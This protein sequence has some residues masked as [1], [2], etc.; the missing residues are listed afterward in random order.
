M[1]LKVK[2]KLQSSS[3]DL[4]PVPANMTHFF[5]PLD[6]TVNRAAKNLTKTEFISY[7]SRCIQQQLDAGKL[8]EDVEVSL[9]LNHCM[10]SGLSTSISFSLL[11]KDEV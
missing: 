10:H 1:C 2:C 8:L 11:T 3:I 5:Q 4:V 7:Y 9:R 6:L